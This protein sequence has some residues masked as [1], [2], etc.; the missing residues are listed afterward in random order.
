[1]LDENKWLQYGFSRPQT[2][3]QGITIHETGNIEMN[4]QQLHDYYNSECKTNECVHYIC[5]D[6][7]VIQ[8]LPDDWAVYNTGKGK[9]FGCRNTIAISICSSLSN[10]KYQKAQDNAVSLIR[11]LLQTYQIGYDLIFSHHNFNNK[12]Y[13]PK[14]ILDRYG[15]IKRF[16]YEEILESEE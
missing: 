11:Q 14:T 12:V 10:E 7:G 4:A 6:S 1:M 13:C 16:I 9:D 8:L 3:I 2:D 5:D 15:S